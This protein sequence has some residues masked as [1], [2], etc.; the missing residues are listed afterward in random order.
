LVANVHL[1]RLSRSCLADSMSAALDE[2]CSTRIW[3][4]SWWKLRLTSLST[5][6]GP[7]TSSC[8]SNQWPYAEVYRC[9]PADLLSRNPEQT[10]FTELARQVAADSDLQGQGVALPKR[11]S[12]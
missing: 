12:Y 6:S 3:F 4:N 9:S 8:L 11:L 5:F 10:T 1:A 2:R 7:M